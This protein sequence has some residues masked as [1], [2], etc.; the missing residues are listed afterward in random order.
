MSDCGGAL[1]AKG[2]TLKNLTVSRKI[3]FSQKNAW[4]FAESFMEESRARAGIGVVGSAT[5][6]PTRAADSVSDSTRHSWS[7]FRA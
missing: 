3:K 2:Y 4:N 6:F 1:M 5:S 7:S